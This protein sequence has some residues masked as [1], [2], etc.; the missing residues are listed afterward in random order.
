MKKLGIGI[1]AAVVVLL[2][3]GAGTS[4]VMGGKVQEGF[5]ATAKD[6]SKPPLAIQVQSYERGLFSSTAKTMWTVNTGDEQLQFT[7]THAISHGPWPRGHAAEIATRFAFSPDAPPEL[8]S[9]YK[10][11][12]PLKWNTQVGWGKTSQHQL[13]SPAVAG[14]FEKDKLSFGGLT[15]D[16]EMSADLKGMKGQAA[17][18]LLQIESTVASADE[19]D[20]ADAGEAI[21]VVIKGNTMR[22]DV[23]Q[24]AGQEFMVGNVKWVLADFNSQP[25][26][27]GE[28]VQFSG[29]SMDID[30]KLEGEVVNT[31][32]NT[33]IQQLTLPKRKISD[34]AVDL[35]L[36]NLDA[37]WLNQFTKHS[38][39]AQGN[40]QAMQALLLGG[41][42]QLLARKP[43]LE[44]KRA[45]WR[46][47][48]GQ[49]ELSAAVSYQGDGSQGLNPATDIQANAK[50]AMPK[51]V[52]Q[53]L[54]SSRVRDAIIADNE[55]DEDYE[56][57]A[58][59]DMVQED[60]QGRI[61]LLLQSGVLQE[62]DGKV[63]TQLEYTGGEVKAN[64]KVLDQE[65]LMG[66]M[67][68]MP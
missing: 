49:S 38:Q 27:G 35:G 14:Q 18:P 53:A 7:A 9:L 50:L 56:P 39:Q 1:A 51:P 2:A 68:A 40:P 32:I 64:G 43:V 60:V 34:I 3:G 30:T 21:N 33:G 36:R 55:G 58:L 29:L 19:L 12:T 17:L 47:E 65:G 45:S 15:A 10:D 63:S 57:Q 8:I 62:Q 5:E 59:A 66:L 23:N 24:P 46:S 48:E 26:F 4:Y 11:K 28:P 6:W 25:K 42:Q 22:F 44:L 41:M 61:S 54:F 67:A 16:F 31:A 13:S 37:G 52:L 20:D